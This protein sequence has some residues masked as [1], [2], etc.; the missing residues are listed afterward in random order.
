M[1]ERLNAIVGAKITEFR[2]KMKEVNASIKALPNK[3]KVKITAITK[4]AEKRIESFQ[5]K[6][7]RLSQ[8]IHSLNTVWSNALRGGL[9]IA[10]PSAI[11][12][13][14]TII[15]LLGTLGPIIAVSG[16][17][18][19]AMAAAFG[20]AGGA[21]I[22]FGAAAIPT[23]KG[24]IDGTAEATAENKKAMEQLDGL[25]KAWKNV[26]KAIAPDSAIA[27]GNAMEGI[28]KAVQAL[29]PMFTSTAKVISDLSTKF[30]AF[31]DSSTAKIF[32][33]FLNQNAAP[34]LEKVSNGVIGL[35]K[36]FMNLTVAFGP[37]ITYMAQGF[38]NLGDSF[39][40]FT[41]KVSNSKG[42]QDFINYVKTNGPK[43]M[44]IIKN[45]GLGLIGMFTAFGPLAS[46]MLT[47]LQRLSEKF[48]LW[49]Q[50]LSQNQQFQSFIGYIRDNAPKVISLIGNIVSTIVNLATS[51]APLGQKMLEIVNGFFSWT[52][53]MLAAHPML[54]KVVGA[55]II[56]IGILQMIIPLI[57]SVTSLFSG[58]GS[59]LARI[60]PTLTAS[61]N[62]FKTN[63]IV[64]LKL[65][66]QNVL[67][68][69]KSFV[70]ATGQMIASAAKAAAQFVVHVAKMVA[71]W[72]I[73]GAKSLVHAAKVAASWVVAMGPVG[74]VIATIIGVAAVVIAN[75]DK[76]KDWTVKTWNKIVD[77]VKSV[78][79]NVKSFL[80]G[81]NLFEIG[82]NMISG[83]TNGIKSMANKVIDS[84]K[85]VV[86]GAI[87]AAKRLLGIHSPSK[88]FK[89]F[90]K[91]TFAGY[92][93]GANNMASKV[94]NTVSDIADVAASTFAP[95]VATATVDTS[96][97]V[98]DIGSIDYAFGMEMDEIELAQQEEQYAVI[99]IGGYEAKGVI[100]YISNE[101]SRINFRGRRKPK[102]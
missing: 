89:G 35:T 79:N 76:I 6:M 82:K 25:K 62:L 96:F 45:F 57:L 30:N 42:L 18:I 3:T 98:P 33:D 20:I 59:V 4:Q 71:Q 88:L 37:L 77:T 39:A 41:E 28:R 83:L 91:D 69:V 9:L 93:I 70:T 36:G 26:Q 58:F 102:Q 49:G 66:G 73:L 34:I 64:G 72:V 47:G 44:D 55:I 43:I 51:M 65:I 101:Q 56:G 78:M 14:A 90:G 100:K 23:I 74:W 10:S 84:V 50:T 52:S 7:D 22:A 24:I 92:V 8:T 97:T 61:F 81:I 85:G 2:R 68:A 75:W 46:D 31:M 67:N 87:K 60:F 16:A 94:K 11:P 13:L 99:N 38:S 29:N 54:G 17:S 63:M 12:I 53:S 80:G 21:A 1:N 5:S 40:A 48:A 95:Q 32:F 86:N 19:V 27:F 15:G